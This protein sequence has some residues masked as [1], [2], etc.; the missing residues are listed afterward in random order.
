METNQDLPKIIIKIAQSLD[1]KICTS[2]GQSKWI[3]NE[4]SRLYSHK[5]RYQCDAIMVGCNTIIKDNPQLN[6]RIGDNEKSI[7]RVILNSTNKIPLDM[8]VF[9]DEN[10]KKTILFYTEESQN[11]IREGHLKTAG[12]NIHKITQKNGEFDLTEILTILKSK[13]NINKIIVE[14][15]AKT[16]SSFLAANLY[17]EIHIFIAPKIFGDGISSF[18][19]FDAKTISNSPNLKLIETKI[20]KDAK[21]NEDNIYLKLVRS[22]V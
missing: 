14:G 9:S 10:R 19:G 21:S 6:I 2:T 13:Y 1:G 8:K 7:W 18:S 4:E 3:T 15:G 22:D 5:L 20:I 11:K 17:D 12:I 16:I